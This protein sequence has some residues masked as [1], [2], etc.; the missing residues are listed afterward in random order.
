MAASYSGCGVIPPA[1]IFRRNREQLQAVNTANGGCI[2]MC[3]HTAILADLQCLHWCV[4]E[5]GMQLLTTPS[6]TTSR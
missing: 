4:C 1:I 5:R 2:D 6:G 3:K